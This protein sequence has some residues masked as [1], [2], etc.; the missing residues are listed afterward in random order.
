MKKIYEGKT[1]NV[2]QLE[3]GNVLLEFKD[4]CTGKDGI[5]DPGENQVGLKIEGIG[6]SNLETSIHFFEILKKEASTSLNR[7]IFTGFINRDNLKSFYC[8]SDVGVFPSL[9]GEAA[10]LTVIEAIHYRLKTIT[11]NAGGIPEYLEGMHTTILNAESPDFIK[12][13]ADSIVKKIDADESENKDHELADKLF[14]EEKYYK[15]FVEISTKIINE[16]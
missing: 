14:S 15:D 2:F 10:G 11:T 7:I 13:L 9:Y 5:F 6:R 8:S 12:E 1:K 16:Q 3:N 4:D